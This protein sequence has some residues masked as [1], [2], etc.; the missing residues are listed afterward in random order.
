MA[1]KDV[2]PGLL[3]WGLT[4]NYSTDGTTYTQMPDLQEFP[5][6][7]GGSPEMIEV[8]TLEDAAHR[9]IMGLLGGD[10]GDGLEFT[11]L[12][13]GK[14]G[15]G[16][17]VVLGLANKDMYWQI[18]TADGITLTW[19]GQCSKPTLTGMGTNE[20]HT[21]TF[22]VSVGEITYGGTYQDPATIRDVMTGPL[23]NP[24]P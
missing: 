7:G 24:G 6:V 12:Y 11:S 8:T 9:Y 22:T 15:S 13:S 21:F 19:Q 3:T 16:W 4:L 18:K 23:A 17:N 2:A 10:N 1:R 20:A 14:N 5:D